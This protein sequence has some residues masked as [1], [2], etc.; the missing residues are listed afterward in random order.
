MLGHASNLMNNVLDLFM[1][2]PIIKTGLYVVLSLMIIFAI[3]AAI[4]NRDV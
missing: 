3:V 1:V 2:D 4:M